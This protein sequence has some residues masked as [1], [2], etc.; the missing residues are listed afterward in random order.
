EV[1]GEAAGR[2]LDAV[3]FGGGIDRRLDGCVGALAPS[4]L[5]EMPHRQR[6]AF[7]A[8][9]QFE[10]AVVGQ[11]VLGRGRGRGRGFNQRCSGG[12]RGGGRQG[13]RAARC[14]PAGVDG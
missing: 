9:E 3:A 1:T 6:Q 5:A 7:R 2:Q 10:H 11:F 4:I 14:T 13:G 12:G 8:V